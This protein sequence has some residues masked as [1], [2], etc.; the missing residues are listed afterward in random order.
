[1]DLAAG[2]SVHSKGRGTQNMLGAQPGIEYILNVLLFKA[3]LFL[4][5]ALFF[6][7]S[8]SEMTQR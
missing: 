6:G 7:S 8:E 4:L 2:R 3:I 1:M 5:R